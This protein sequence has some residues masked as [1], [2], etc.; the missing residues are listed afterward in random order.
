MWEDTQGAKM[1]KGGT[2]GPSEIDE[3]L[4]SYLG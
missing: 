3:T 2:G 4:E 1:R